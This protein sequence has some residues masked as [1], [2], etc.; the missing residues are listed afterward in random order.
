MSGF[1]EFTIPIPRQSGL[2]GAIVPAGELV[3]LPASVGYI[4]KYNTS[5]GYITKYV[6]TKST[7]VYAPSSELGLSQPLPVGSPELYI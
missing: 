2:H 6:Y 1:R 7:T 3:F 5:I 4:P